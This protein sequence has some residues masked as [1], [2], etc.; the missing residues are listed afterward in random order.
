MLKSNYILYLLVGWIILFSSCTNNC[1]TGDKVSYYLQLDNSTEVF[2]SI[3]YLGTTKVFTYNSNKIDWPISS[4]KSQVEMYIT[5]NYRK[6]TIVYRATDT[7]IYDVG[8]CEDGF[9]IH[10]LEPVLIA[11]TFD[12]SYWKFSSEPAGAPGDEHYFRTLFLK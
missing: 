11:K 3:R 9:N 1:G 10:H 6:D 7:L 8:T 4:A 2:Q 5:T 12:S